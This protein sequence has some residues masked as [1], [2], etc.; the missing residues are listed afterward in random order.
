MPPSDTGSS[1][2]RT[3]PAVRSRKSSPRGA[4]A[5]EVAT[6]TATVAAA[7]A[8]VVRE[9]VSAASQ[10]SAAMTGASSRGLGR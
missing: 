7:P 5:S 6:S 8:P 3:V 1:S 2:H 9:S 10:Y 4:P